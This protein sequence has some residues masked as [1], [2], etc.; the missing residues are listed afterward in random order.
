MCD[1]CRSEPFTSTFPAL[2]VASPR[3][4][5]GLRVERARIR[6]WS[7][8]RDRIRQH[9]Q[10]VGSRAAD[11]PSVDIVSRAAQEH[12]HWLVAVRRRDGDDLAFGRTVV[13]V[14]SRPE[15]P[16]RDGSERRARVTGASGSRTSITAA[17]C[18]SLA[19][20]ESL[21]EFDVRPFV[22]IRLGDIEPE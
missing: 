22:A 21:F 17:T 5:A 1:R 12:W 8:D 16:C 19:I 6:E 4:Q 14:R 7:S 13:E 20:T 2:V 18:P 3:D 10:L 11:A 9:K 15:C